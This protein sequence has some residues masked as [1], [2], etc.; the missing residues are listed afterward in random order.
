MHGGGAVQK[1]ADHGYPPKRQCEAQPALGQRKRK[2]PERMIDEMQGN[3][4]EEHET[5]EQPKPPR[6]NWGEQIH[7]VSHVHALHRADHLL[8]PRHDRRA[9][10]NA[11]SR[12]RASASGACRSA[13]SWR[14]ER[15]HAW[16]NESRSRGQRRA[17]VAAGGSGVRVWFPAQR[18]CVVASRQ[19]KP[20]LPRVESSAVGLLTF[21]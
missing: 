4:G 7:L 21:T 16:I 18:R 9:L 6:C 10:W 1:K 2:Y 20:K 11:I 13:T 14:E 17:P 8:R 19:A 12:R 5:R 15:D 3:V